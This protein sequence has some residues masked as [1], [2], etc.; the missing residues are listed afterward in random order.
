M[1]NKNNINQLVLRDSKTYKSLY[2]WFI[3]WE[4]KNGEPN[5]GGLIP[6]DGHR[7]FT[8]KD[9]KYFSVIQRRKDYENQP[10]LKYTKGR[11]FV[12]YVDPSDP[13]YDT[14]YHFIDG[15]VIEEIRVQIE[16][17]EYK[18]NETE[19]PRGRF[20]YEFGGTHQVDD[21]HEEERNNSLTIY[22]G[23]D[24]NSFD[25]LFD[26]FKNNK[27]G[28]LSLK[29]DGPVD[30]FYSDWSPEWNTY[31]ISIL[32][33]DDRDKLINKSKNKIEPPTLGTFDKFIIINEN[34][35]ILS[36]N[37]D[38]KLDDLKI[39]DHE[40]IDDQESD[41]KEETIIN[42]EMFSY[43]ENSSKEVIKVLR[44]IRSLSVP[45]R[46][47]TEEIELIKS[48][49]DYLNET[50]KEKRETRNVLIGYGILTIWIYGL[51]LIFLI[52]SLF[53][54]MKISNLKDD[55]KKLNS[56]WNGYI[57]LQSKFESI[58]TNDL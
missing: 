41:Q 23:L 53:I 30:G 12:G 5:D 20:W 56:K 51:G 18:E 58:E 6:Y 46:N 50:I 11:R 16:D 2:D 3:S 31:F 8:F 15:G 37:N 44:E 54:H 22:I 7:S 17:V 35:V 34:H 40:P 39:E 21:F 29:I 47:I 26:E 52:I 1:S 24:K 10:K 14:S 25:S 4:E 32:T 43:F 19:F 55:V 48:E 28:K 33:D 27:I 57:N 13:H 38:K 42:E 9:L 49:I 45:R 36:Q